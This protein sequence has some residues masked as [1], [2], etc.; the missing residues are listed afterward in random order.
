MLFQEKKT[1]LQGCIQRLGD[2]NPENI[3]KRGYSITVRKDTKK[4]VSDAAQ[5][6]SGDEVSV[7]LHRGSI[8]CKVE[9]IKT[10]A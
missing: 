4:V 8:D 10:T 5:V 6:A 1:S 2:L 7:Q 3:L 9:K